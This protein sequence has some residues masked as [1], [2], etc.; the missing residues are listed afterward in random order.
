M[1]S[2]QTFTWGG[3]YTFKGTDLD[4]QD[5][6]ALLAASP[7]GCY[8]PFPPASTATSAFPP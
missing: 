5:R 7:L 2:H 8:T 1:T 4:P 3:R 6:H